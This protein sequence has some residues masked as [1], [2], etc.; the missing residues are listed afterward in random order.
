MNLHRFILKKTVDSIRTT[1]SKSCSKSFN[2][3]SIRPC[4]IIK[5][6]NM[7]LLCFVFYFYFFII[8]YFLFVFLL[9]F[10]LPC[11]SFVSN[12]LS[13]LKSHFSSLSFAEFNNSF[14]TSVYCFGPFYV[15]I[16]QKLYFQFL[17]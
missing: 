12:L 7:F 11:N 17:V 15:L 9:I 4:L 14:W 16:N 8:L 3:L 1:V 6:D 10:I 13:K 5:L 2:C